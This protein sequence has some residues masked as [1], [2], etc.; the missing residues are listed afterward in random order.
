MDSGTLFSLEN[1]AENTDEDI[2]DYTEIVRAWMDDNPD[3]AAALTS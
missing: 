2:S 1:V 3:W